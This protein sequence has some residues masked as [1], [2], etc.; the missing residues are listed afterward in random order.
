[1]HQRIVNVIA[2]LRQDVASHLK[3]ST[4]HRNRAAIGH[5]WRACV[6]EPA[7]IIHIFMVHVL[8]G[9]TALSHLRYLTGLNLT[10]QAICEARLRLPLELFRRLVRQVIPTFRNTAPPDGL[11]HGH[12]TFAIDGSSFSMPDT[13]ELQAVFGQPG[14]QAQGCGF[15]VARFLA[16]FDSATG[17]LID[18]L[19]A[20][21]R[22]RDMSRAGVSVQG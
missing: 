7:T 1:M 12:R 4:I 13:P 10:A 8:N 21:L 15:P 18:V 19:S 3:R 2:A 16:L 17:F 20:P 22:T 6:L 5:I 11:W 14:N 9:N